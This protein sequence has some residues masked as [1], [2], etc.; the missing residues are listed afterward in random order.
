MKASQ[1]SRSGATISI[2]HL[3]YG[4]TYEATTQTGF[5]STG[6][7]LGVEVAY[8]DWRILLRGQTDIHSIA[9]D[10]LESVL[11]AAA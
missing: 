10:Q 9:I 1:T 6:E 4:D 2:N 8:D 11:A 3:R 7:Y 5:V